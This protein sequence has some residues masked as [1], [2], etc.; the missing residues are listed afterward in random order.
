[1][2]G[3]AQKPLPLPRSLPWQVLDECHHAKDNHPTA[4][5]LQHY[6]SSARQTQAGAVSTAFFFDC[7]RCCPR[8]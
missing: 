3:Q 7:V 4:K 8:T 1:M 2:S 5:I 6:H